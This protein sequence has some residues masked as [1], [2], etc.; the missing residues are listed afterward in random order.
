M[1]TNIIDINHRNNPF[2][3]LHMYGIFQNHVYEC[4]NHVSGQISRTQTTRIYLQVWL[5]ARRHIHRDLAHVIRREQIC[6]DIKEVRKGVYVCA[7]LD[8]Q[9]RFVCMRK[10]AKISK[11]CTNASMYVQIW[12]CINFVYEC[13]NLP[14]YQGGA[15]TRLC[16]WMQIH[17]NVCEYN[18]MFF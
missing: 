16:M 13:T 3:S 7:T 2:S 8:V 18:F 5:N 11:R 1:I 9:K 10:F 15:Q 6:Q 17:V 12:M 4:S 14:R